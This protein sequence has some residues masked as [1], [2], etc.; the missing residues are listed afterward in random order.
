MRGGGAT[1]DDLALN[2][3]VNIVVEPEGDSCLLLQVTEDDVD[4]LDRYFA[5]P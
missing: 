1:Y 3:E 5:S 4:R 2:A